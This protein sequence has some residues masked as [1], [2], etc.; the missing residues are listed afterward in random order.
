[1]NKYQKIA[2]I[3]ARYELNNENP[4]TGDENKMFRQKRNGIYSINMKSKC[5]IKDAI[6]FKNYVKSK[7]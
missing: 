1:M 4:F 3:L 2:C 7:W 5:N 6:D